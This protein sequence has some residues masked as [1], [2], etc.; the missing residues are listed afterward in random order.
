[1]QSTR[2]GPRLPGLLSILAFVGTA[3]QVSGDIVLVRDGQPA[4]SIV[5]PPNA[6]ETVRFAAAELARYLGEIS[7]AKV[8]VVAEGAR[9]RG[10]PVHVG[11]TAAART[12]LPDRLARQPESVFVRVSTDR[13]VIVGGS[14]RGTLF[15]VYRFLETCLGCR[16]PAPD[17]DFVPRRSTLSVPD[18]T[19]ASAPTFDLRLFIAQSGKQAAACMAWGLKLGLN[20]FYPPDAATRN[21]ESYF[22]PPELPSCHTY[23]RVIPNDTYFGSHP[24]WFPRIGGKR[25][26]GSLHGRQL[27][28]TAPGLA[29]EFARR[30]DEILERNPRCRITSISPNDGRG[31]CECPVCMALDKKLCGGRATRQ[32]LAGERPFRGDR[33][34]WFANQV[35]RRVAEKHPNVLLLELAYINY[36]EPPDTI[37]PLAN[38]VPWVCHY[39]PADY[40]KPIADPASE[41]N[42]Q[43]NALLKRW[44]RVTPDVL[45]YAYVSKSMWWRLPRPVL[46]PFAADVKYF[47]RLGIHRY[48]AQSRLGDWPLDGPLY[49]VL[50][51]MLWDPGLDPQALAREWTRAMFGPAAAAMDRFYAEID[52]AVRAS[53]KPYSDNP[54]RD[55]PGLFAPP[56]IEAARQALT[57]AVR[58]VADNPNL[59]ERVEKVT[60]VF[61]YGRWMIR[62]IEAAARFRATGEAGDYQTAVQAGRRAL[63]FLR[64]REAKKFVDHLKLLEAFGVPASGMGEAEKKGGRTCWNTDETGKGD[65]RAGWALLYAR[66]PDPERPAK[67]VMD[68]WGESDLQTIVINTGGQGK[69]YADGGIWKPVEPVQP[70]SG[71]PGWETLTFVVPPSLFAPGKKTQRIGLGGGDSQIWIANVRVTAAD[72]ADP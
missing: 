27:C 41:P 22:L 23:H 63:S 64:V 51:K 33:V 5:T 16:W 56:H 11:L 48:Y 43:F 39:A 40:S 19:I 44:V 9:I 24:E 15:A 29:D 20:G 47:H 1:M 7:G 32:G 69:G 62:C 71:K 68:V 50:G 6:A 14:D 45:I 52:A 70:L 8:P 28:V 30:I 38:V 57:A 13:V 12:A 4:S 61:D 35:A 18:R 10:A 65:G 21:G 34:F 67:I 54:P 60:R 72:K 59:K 3:I 37:R 31:W 46:R 25:L 49:Y 36:A 66:I 26:P 58:T 53:G 55:V 17:I 42:A 2:H